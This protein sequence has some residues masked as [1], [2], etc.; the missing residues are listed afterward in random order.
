MMVKI[1]NVLKEQRFSK[2]ILY[3][4]HLSKLPFSQ[5]LNELQALTRELHYRQVL[6]PQ[7][8]SIG[9]SIDVTPRDTLDV[10]DV[11]HVSSGVVG[12]SGWKV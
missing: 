10:R 7:E 3:S 9:H 4:T 8:V 11:D 12:G 2:M 5:L 6:S 1:V